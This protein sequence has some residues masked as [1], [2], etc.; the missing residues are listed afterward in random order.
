[1]SRQSRPLEPC[2][3]LICI[4]V[5]ANKKLSPSHL[6]RLWL[7]LS[8]GI[9]LCLVPG[10][11]LADTQ[12][13]LI[14]ALARRVAPSL[15]REGAQLD[16]SNRSGLT[17][18]EFK[19]LT[20]IFKSEL[21]QRGAKITSN[22]SGTEI[23]LTLSSSL[24]SCMGIVEIRRSNQKSEVFVGSLG[25]PEGDHR[26]QS[27]ST[28]ALHKELLFSQE[29]PLLDAAF[30]TSF[31]LVDTLGRGEFGHYEW[32]DGR[33]SK[34]STQHLPPNVG[35]SRDLQGKVGHSVDAFAVSYFT[36]F[37]R[38]E[39]SRGMICE[40][41]MQPWPPYGVVRDVLSEK[42]TP[43]WFSAAEFT[44]NDEEAIVITGKDGLARLYSRGA[45]PAATFSGWGSEVASIRSGCGNGWQILV[46]G[47]GDWT[48]PDT[49]KAL[50][51]EGDQT[52]GVAPPIDFPGP[53][54]KLHTSGSGPLSDNDSNGA[55]AIVQNLSTGRY[56][57]YLLT[58]DCH[59]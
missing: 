36:E 7:S 34:G 8:L 54:I 24:A 28:F 11:L 29:S 32:K 21:E 25:Q 51:V 27:S 52:R 12:D 41:Q 53:I 44:M 37:C 23:L 22:G 10:F 13:D 45:E 26:D 38:E 5:S 56:E 40:K 42:K 17:E 47:T 2:Y 33:W 31:P 30:Y 50:E 35:M 55:I 46:S 3:H 16:A 18:S 59:L 6:Y 1:M 15:Q 9:A 4:P 48:A 58:I 49:L 43:P 19:R 20:G 39:T 14:R 57:V